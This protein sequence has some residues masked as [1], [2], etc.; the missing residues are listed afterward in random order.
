MMIPVMAH[1]IILSQETKFSNTTAEDVLE[2]IKK[3]TPVP[4]GK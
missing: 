2:E 4:T 3:S 1:R